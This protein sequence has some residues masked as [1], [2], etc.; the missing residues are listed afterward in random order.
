MLWHRYLAA[1]H[2]GNHAI[3]PLCVNQTAAGLIRSLDD[4]IR[5]FG[6][7]DADADV[8][9]YLLMLILMLLMSTR[10]LPA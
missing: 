7:V 2:V 3:L 9:A 8:D 4:Q 5:A 6:D 10:Q 1:K